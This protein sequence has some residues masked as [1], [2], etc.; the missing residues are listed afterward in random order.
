MS[1]LDT[2]FSRINHLGDTT[3]ERI[4]NGGIRSFEK[5]MAESPHTV[6]NLS[7]E[8]GIYFKGIILTNKDKEYTKIMFLN[9]SNNIPLK[10]GDI[11]NWP[12]ENKDIE[13]W[14]L[15][16]EEKKVNGTYR[17]FW[18]VRCNY[19][20]KW[21]DANGHLQQSWSYIVSSVDSKIK[22]NYRTWNSLIS[23]QPNKYAEILMPRY[24]IE[25]ATNF[26]VEEESWQVIE[27]DHTSVP[28]IIY[29][30]L[31]ENKI[32]KVLDDVENGIADTDKRAKYELV[33]PPTTQHFTV[34]AEITPVFTV[35]KNG[36]PFAARVEY[37]PID[38]SVA[39]VLGGVLTAI[40]AGETDI[41][42]K[43]LDCTDIDPD[44]LSLH[45]EITE[46]S[47]EFSCYIEGPDT[48][49]LDRIG[50]YKLVSSNGE[51][52]SKVIFEIN[53]S[54]LATIQETDDESEGIIKANN[55]NIL[56]TFTLKAYI[57]EEGKTKEQLSYVTKE[58]KVIPLW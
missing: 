56:G 15:I 57:V 4:R 30:S 25:R 35:M 28:G 46:N 10:V 49:R 51:I 16:Q 41:Q 6:T 9:V 2:Y 43:L 52:I 7:V 3:A 33:L 54:D 48:I 8:R 17:T 45:I 13:K 29:L 42:I 1:Y 40:G 26:I 53:D 5:W 32:N 22:G 58:V 37:I 44:V 36:I 47:T 50:K 14:I 55:K 31:T 38:K 23:P 11:M 24:P 39:R 34:G 20:L 19:L 27:Y 18:I 12:Q 21:I